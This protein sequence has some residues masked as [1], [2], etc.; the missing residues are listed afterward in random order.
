MKRGALIAAILLALAPLGATAQ[1][2]PAAPAKPVPPRQEPPPAEPEGPVYEPQLLKLSEIIG[3]LAYLRTLC[4]AA[5]AQHWHDRMTALVE[6]EGRTPQRRN[7]LTAAF[8]RGFKAYALTHRSCTD[9]SQ[10]AAARLAGEGEQ[11]SRALA[12]RYGG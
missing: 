4:G 9:A 8:N 5:E 7:R 2:R 10:E 12:G 11:L 3:S 1:P 6:A